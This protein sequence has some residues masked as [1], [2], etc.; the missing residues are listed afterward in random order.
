MLTGKSVAVCWSDEVNDYLCR[1]GEHP[2]RG[3]VTHSA[4]E[5][6]SESRASEPEQ[7]LKVTALN[8]STGMWVKS[9]LMELCACSSGQVTERRERWKGWGL[10][11][12]WEEEDEQKNMSWVMWMFRV[13]T[14]YLRKMQSVF[15]VLVTSVQWYTLPN[16]N[17]L[18]NNTNNGTE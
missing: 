14:E 6:G 12:R 18:Y 17:I 16:T 1:W 7:P 13:I 10:E 3:H 8:D 15:D 4:Y 9:T 11:E 5:S 2:L